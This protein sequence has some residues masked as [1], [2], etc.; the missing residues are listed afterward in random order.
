M[1]AEVGVSQE[2]PEVASKYRKLRELPL[3][4]LCGLPT[5]MLCQLY[6]TNHGSL[7]ESG[8]A[9][10][11]ICTY[12]PFASDDYHPSAGLRRC[13]LDFETLTFPQGRLK[14]FLGPQSTLMILSFVFAKQAFQ[15]LSQQT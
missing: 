8:S 10:S 11:C 5:P 3:Q 2:M 15:L 12:F 4:F 13:L 6:Q 1:E 9:P 7:R 14:V